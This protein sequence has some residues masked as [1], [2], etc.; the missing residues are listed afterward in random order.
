MTTTDYAIPVA[1]N[2][3]LGLGFRW[4]GNILLGS[5]SSFYVLTPGLAIGTGFNLICEHRNGNL[6]EK[7]LRRSLSDSLT[8]SMAGVTCGELSGMANDYI[9]MPFFDKFSTMM[10]TTFPLMGL[11][12]TENATPS[13]LKTTIKDGFGAVANKA[14]SKLKSLRPPSLR[15]MLAIAA[16]VMTG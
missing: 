3:A 1:V 14:A 12:A 15:P 9:L 11:Y 2:Y 4:V 7:G 10:Q 13:T 6:K 8:L 16:P 5:E